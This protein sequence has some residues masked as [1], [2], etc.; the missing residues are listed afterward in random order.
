L[1]FAAIAA[2]RKNEELAA[3]PPAVPKI[4]AGN[5]TAYRNF[6]AFHHFWIAPAFLWREKP[7]RLVEAGQF[8]RGDCGRAS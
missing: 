3:C 5:T 7:E 2:S 6:L 4:V 8:E 1:E